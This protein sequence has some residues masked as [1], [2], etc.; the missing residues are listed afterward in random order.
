MNGQERGPAGRPRAGFVITATVLLWLC[1]GFA[2]AA[3]W[4]SYD[5]FQ[6]VILVAVS[7]LV[8]SAI[9][10]LGAMLRWSSLLVMVATILAY[11]LLGVPLAVPGR[12]I[13][14]VFPSFD[15]LREL[16]A[17]SALGWKQLLTISLP[18][19]SYQSLLVPAFLLV[20]VTVVVSLS[21]ALRARFGELAVLGP[22]VVF[23]VGI[24]FGPE[25]ALWPAGLTIGLTA[26]ILLTLMWRRWYRRRES[27]RALAITGMDSEGRPVE[28]VADGGFVGFR[29]LLSAGL[30]MAVAA[31]ASIAAASAL[32]PEGERVVLRTT[33]AQPFDPRDYPSPLSGFRG[34]EKPAQASAMMLTVT[35]LPE[36]ARVRLATMDAYDGVVY[37]VGS[38]GLDSASGSFARVPLAVDRSGLAG[39]RVSVGVRLGAYSGVWLPTVGSLASVDFRGPGATELGDNFYFN[40]ATGT[41]AVLGGVGPGEEYTVTA[42]LPEQPAASELAKL[43]PGTVALPPVGLVPDDLTA[44]LDG[45]VEGVSG[46]G[47]R[48][49]AMLDGLRSEGYVSHGV[50]AEEPPSR[51]GHSADRI[52]QLLTDQRMIGDQEQYAVTAALMARSLGFP[53]RVV[54]GFAPEDVNPRGETRIVGADVSAW[55]EVDTTEYGW[56][57]IDPTPPARPIPDELPEEPSKVSR[58]QSPVQPAP[59]DVDAR[60][61]QIPSDAS[62]EDAPQDDAVL[63]IVVR[64]LL[65]LGWAI[66]VLAVLLSPFITI[67][68]AKWRRRRLR[69]RAPSALQR[70]AGGW[71]EFE[72]AVL[73]HGYTPGPAPTRIEVAQVVG[74]TQP[75]VLAVVADRA[76]FS[77]GEP[78]EEQ[79]EQLWR[80]V[81]ELRY[82]LDAELST[83]ERIKSLVSLRSLGGYS[84]KSLFKR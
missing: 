62:Q 10:V 83:W 76:I 53:A 11:F 55:I 63:A 48:L 13:A 46:P 43:H 15:G 47:A 22:I 69:R 54:F 81:E 28:A 77:P 84:V 67:V 34:Y 4:P 2:T 52:T 75:F 65:A 7:T 8:G 49:V 40:I 20:L 80:S 29:S 82:T 14:G 58:P 31:A 68:A 33:I 57:T 36:G 35:G 38:S 1:F 44:T 25:R 26:S 70:I 39:E 6:F 66:L 45:Y 61:S 74:G 73:D 64:V 32:P 5:D 24:L 42:V 30:I 9:A 23:V 12:A 50:S 59:S 72:D 21:V 37:A 41:A 19:G 17:G 18:V 16:L 79:A 78:D 56:V 60:D 51:S 27:I 3:L 71:Q